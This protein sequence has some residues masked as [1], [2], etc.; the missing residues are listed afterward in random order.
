MAEW[1]ASWM[2]WL[3]LMGNQIEVSNDIQTRLVTYAG[4]VG[5]TVRFGQ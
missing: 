5:R 3:V 2:A 1:H 4:A